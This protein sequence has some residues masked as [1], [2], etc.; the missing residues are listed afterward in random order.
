MPSRDSITVNLINRD[1]CALFSFSLPS[2][3]RSAVEDRIDLTLIRIL[4]IIL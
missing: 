3:S 2:S 1:T 4:S